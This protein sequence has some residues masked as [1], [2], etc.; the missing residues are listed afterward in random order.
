MQS[1]I[2]DTSNH[3]LSA[4]IH[5]IPSPFHHHNKADDTAGV[6]L[7]FFSRFYPKAPKAPTG[8]WSLLGE[9]TAEKEE[10]AKRRI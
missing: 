9:K 8:F 5:G 4:Y 7:S 6:V 2:S 10:N 1:N 3:W